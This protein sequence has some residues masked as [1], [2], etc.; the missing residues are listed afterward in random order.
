MS[1]SI[2]VP[3]W[4]SNG[5]MRIKRDSLL[6]DHPES[7]YRYIKDKL[8]LNP[9]EYGFYP[10]SLEDLEAEAW[11]RADAAAWPGIGSPPR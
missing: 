1:N 6:S 4:Y 10:D 3:V 2:E 9:E 11:Y 8:K 5:I 7:T